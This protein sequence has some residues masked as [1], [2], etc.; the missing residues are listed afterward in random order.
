[1]DSLTIRNEREEDYRTVEEITRDAFWNQ[2]VPG[3]DE[4]YLV[5]LIRVS[6]DFIPSLTFVAELDGR[7]VGSIFFTDSYI[8]DDGGEKHDTI[9]FG[10]VSVIPELQGKGV[11]AALIKHAIQAATALGHKA[12]FIYGYP[13]YYKRF[14]FCHAKDFGISNP[15]GKYPY[16]HLALELQQGAL[17]QITGKAFESGVFEFDKD[18]AQEYD[19][20]FSPK[21]KAVTPSQS[22]FEETLARFL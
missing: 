14:G 10:P 4:H 3:C 19:R 13:E 12:I 17:A 5:H 6:P 9:T 7:I 21:D 11:G 20:Q 15:E 2:Y 8:L 1:M 16:A 22:L 18:A